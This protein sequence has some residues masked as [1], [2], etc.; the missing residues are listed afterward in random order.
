MASLGGGGVPEWDVRWGDRCREKGAAGVP[1][2]VTYT[3]KWNKSDILTANQMLVTGFQSNRVSFDIIFTTT[4]LWKYIYPLHFNQ[5]DF[6]RPPFSSF[7]HLSHLPLTSISSFSRWAFFHGACRGSTLFPG[8][9][10]SPRDNDHKHH[11]SARTIRDSKLK[12]KDLF[13]PLCSVG[14]ADGGSG[15]CWGSFPCQEERG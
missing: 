6:Q 2:V 12:I 9:T 7:W 3:W 5:L 15:Y 14:K 4:L 10:H 11:G 8:P 1:V 13:F